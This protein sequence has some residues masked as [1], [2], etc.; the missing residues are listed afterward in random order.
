MHIAY[1]GILEMEIAASIHS[2]NKGNK[3]KVPI[4]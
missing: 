1:S 4:G 2:H 3:E